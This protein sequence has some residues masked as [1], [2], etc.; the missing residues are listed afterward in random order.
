MKYRKLTY[1]EFIKRLEAGKYAGVTGARRA[2]G[3]V[4]L[5]KEVVNT[6]HE[7]VNKHFSVPPGRVSPKRPPY[8]PHILKSPR[9]KD[10]NKDKV[11]RFVLAVPE[12]GERI[13][14]TITREK[15][16]R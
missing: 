14:V 6:M 4:D 9:S 2:I 12:V 8:V 1:E 10:A 3:N 7:A 15:S 16:R 5:P 11:A 13:T